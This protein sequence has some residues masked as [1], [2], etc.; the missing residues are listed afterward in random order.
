MTRLLLSTRYLILLPILGLPLAAAAFFVIGGYGLIKLLIEIISIALNLAPPSEEMAQGVIIFEVVEYVHTFLVGTV[1]YITAMGLYQLFIK[2]IDF[3]NWLKIGSTE[4][5]ETNLIGVTVVVL[6]VNFM[7]AIFARGTETTGLLQ[8]GAGIAL[9]IAALG[10]FIGLRAW[11]ARLNKETEA[12]IQYTKGISAWK[13]AEP[14]TE[15]E[16]ARSLNRPSQMP[17]MG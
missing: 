3:P 17:E 10:V 6:A 8:Y 2:E 12:S 7:G 15:D 14:K 5:L 13:Q 4:E 11:S 1:L 9:P 16:L